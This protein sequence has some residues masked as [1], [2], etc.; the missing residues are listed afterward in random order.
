MKKFEGI[1]VDETIQDLTTLTQP[2]LCER[3][4]KFDLDL[5]QAREKIA[6]RM[7]TRPKNCSAKTVTIF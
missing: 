6:P 3:K 5:E 1:R 4:I 7:R 2:G